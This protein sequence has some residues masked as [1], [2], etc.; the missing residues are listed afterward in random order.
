MGRQA[1]GDH[2]NNDYLTFGRTRLRRQK[3]PLVVFGHSLGDQDRHLLDALNSRPPGRP[4]AVSV[5]PR[6]TLANRNRQAELRRALAARDLYFF[7]ASTH[8]LGDP[9]LAIDV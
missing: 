8:P 3:P 9:G 1:A 7:D 4:I 2:L 5:L 6:T